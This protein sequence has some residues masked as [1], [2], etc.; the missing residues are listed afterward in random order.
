MSGIESLGFEVVEEPAMPLGGVNTIP[1]ATKML[2]E[3]GREGDAYMVHA[4]EGET[5]VPF[6]VFEANP[7]LKAMVFNQIQEMGLDPR[8]YVVGNEMNSI[9][10][11]TGAPEFFFSNPFS[12]NL[13]FSR[14]IFDNWLGFIGKQHGI[15]LSVLIS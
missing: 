9:N 4:A 11:A 1:E 12:F 13:F 14:V 3:L 7:R 8:R 2:A 10:P 15:N 5:V 6:E